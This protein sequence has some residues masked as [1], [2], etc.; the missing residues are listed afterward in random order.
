MSITNCNCIKINTAQIV[1]DCSFVQY[2]SMCCPFSA[3]TNR[4]RN[5]NQS[6]ALSSWSF[7]FQ[8]YY[9]LKKDLLAF[10]R[11]YVTMSI[12]RPIIKK[13][14]LPAKKPLNALCEKRLQSSMFKW[15]SF[16]NFLEFHCKILNSYAINR[17]KK[18]VKILNSYLYAKKSYALCLRVQFLANPVYSYK[19]TKFIQT[20]KLM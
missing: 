9:H 17:C 1:G 16:Y 2:L 11:F 12:E 14:T 10:R 15:T 4:T 19:L 7:V 20:Y 5:R 6:M 3:I 13:V 8:S 18:M